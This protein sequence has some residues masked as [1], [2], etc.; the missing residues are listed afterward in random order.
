METPYTAE[1]FGLF[2]G[3]ISGTL[4][5]RD[6]TDRQKL[7]QIQDIVD[8]HNAKIEAYHQYKLDEAIRRAISEGMTLEEA[9]R[10]FGMEEVDRP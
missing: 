1:G 3:A 6:L 4:K 7:E 2:A 8:E 9:K 5:C 10:F